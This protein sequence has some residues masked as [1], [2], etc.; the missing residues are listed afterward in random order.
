MLLAYSQ[1][2]HGDPGI[3]LA[4]G[5]PTNDDFGIEV[6]ELIWKAEVRTQ[7]NTSGDHEE[8]QDYSF[9][10]PAVT[11]LPDSTLLIAFWLIQPDAAPRANAVVDC[12]QRHV[13]LLRLDPSY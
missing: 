5:Q 9:G 2:Q 10:D 4:V 8:W 11:V 12:R 3:R 7:S 13:Q 1:R 6:D